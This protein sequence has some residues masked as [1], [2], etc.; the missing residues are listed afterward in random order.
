MCQSVLINIKP[1]LQRYDEGHGILKQVMWPW[2]RPFG[3]G[4]IWP[5][6]SMYKISRLTQ[7]FILAL[8]SGPLLWRLLQL[9]FYR[10][11]TFLFQSLHWRTLQLFVYINEKII[12]SPPG[13]NQ[14][15][16]WYASVTFFPLLLSSSSSSFL[17]IT[18]KPY[19]ENIEWPYPGS[20][21]MLMTW[22]W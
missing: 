10:S 6:Y 5:T 11:N 4:L 21:C 15:A 3:D 2:H 19:L 16:Y 7:P 8:F 12:I 20:C 22:L 9:D 1:N 14:Q 17:M 18:W 13:F